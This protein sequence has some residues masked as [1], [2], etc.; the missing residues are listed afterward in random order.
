[1]SL[2]LHINSILRIG[3]LLVRIVQPRMDTPESSASAV[4]PHDLVAACHENGFITE[5]IADQVIKGGSIEQKSNLHSRW[6]S[7][8]LAADAGLGRIRSC[9]PHKSGI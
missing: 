7:K 8:I 5:F 4:A 1:M 2:K 6:N 9:T 3:A